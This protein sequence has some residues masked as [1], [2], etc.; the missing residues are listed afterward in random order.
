MDVATLANFLLFFG[1][2]AASLAADDGATRP[3]APDPDSLYDQADY[4]RT[5][6]L[7][8]ED[9]EV[10]AD[11]DNLA[12]FMDGGDDSLTGSSGNDYADLGTGDDSAS[13]GAGNDIIEAGTGND[14]VLGG[15]GNDLGLGDA[16][17]DNFFGDLG[18]DSLGGEDGNDT[19]TGGSGADILSGGLGNDVISG[20][21]SLG[22]ATGS[23]TFSEGTDQLFGGTG[24]D[25]LILG[26]GD[27]A[28]GGAGADRFE[29]DARWRDGADRFV[30][31][32]YAAGEDSLVLHYAQAYDPDTS[33]A[34]S[35]IVTVQASADGLSSLIVVNGSVVAIVEGV[36]DLDAED[37]S[38]L[39]DTE[40]D[41]TYRPENFD[42]VL[43][44]T[45]ANDT[46][47]GST[48]ED[49]GSFGGGDDSASG[50]DGQDS[51]RGD[52]GDDTLAGDA[53]NDTLIGGAEDDALSGGTGNDG[54][55]GDAGN[56]LLEGGDGTDRLF[57]GGGDDT[58]SGF[59]ADSAGGSDT[60]IDGA[61]TL[62][63]GAGDDNLLV[64]RGDT[65]TGGAG[66]DSFALD[67]SVN[68]DASGF[69]TIQDY[70]RDTDRIELH[71][72]PVLNGSGV[73]VPPTVTILMGPSNAYAVILFNGEPLAHV[74]GAT[75]LTLADITLVPEA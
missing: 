52:A 75:S 45:E 56:D 24:D 41:T 25:R 6:R 50:N 60:A 21:S 38:L 44:G 20:F 47:T 13:M 36:T 53:G 46:Q 19:L 35:P 59:D 4:S 11:A 69:A 37:I 28:T 23:L 57:G 55:S 39:A 17:D 14:T 33:L 43:E 5:D 66:S 73:E 26:R 64:G 31:S 9:D 40:T 48:G 22:G 10:A 49:Y 7:G 16:G 70:V 54:L 29:M 27:V 18:N 71:Y 2:F 3:D 34:V 67:A 32:D 72:T 42:D 62:S 74:T 65:G 63:G 30:I 51:L 8:A 15:N 58:L 61:D 68:E 1:A 12:W